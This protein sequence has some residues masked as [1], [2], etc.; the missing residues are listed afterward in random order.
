M[1]ID[2]KA[3]KPVPNSAE[4]GCFGCGARNPHGLKMKFST[5]GKR[6]YSFMQV[7]PT[8]TGWDRT[9]HGGVLST[10]LDEIM[11]W[12]VICLLKKIGVTKSMT[13]DFIKSVNAGERLTVVG[14]VQEKSSERSTLMTGAIY[15]PDD[16]VCVKATA[17]FTTMQPR[18][19][20]RLGLVG[21]DCLKM[22]AP[23][24]NSK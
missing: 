15:N 11:G 13:T 7:P 5:D 22:L 1:I 23:A 3:L 20:I 14:A 12:A 4:H 17:L 21:N 10:I 2:P 18:A 6:I 9:V 24:L 8:M 19:A 16:T